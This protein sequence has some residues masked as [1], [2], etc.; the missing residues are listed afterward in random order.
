[1]SI[2]SR[3][4]GSGSGALAAP[5]PET[6]EG[7]RILVDPIKEGGGYRLA[8]TIEKEVGGEVKSHRMIRADVFT[9]EDE[10]KQFSLAKAR[11]MIDQQGE[12]LFG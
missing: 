3:L 11:Q 8:A 10:A 9:S 6:Y 7:F 2:L 12:A 5:E 1:M 4:F